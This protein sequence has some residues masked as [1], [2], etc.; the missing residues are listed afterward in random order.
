MPGMTTGL[1]IGFN[2][3]EFIEMKKSL[4]E[5]I[6]SLETNANIELQFEND[7]AASA[8][9]DVVKE[10]KKIKRTYCLVSKKDLEQCLK[11][12]EAEI[13]MQREAGE[14]TRKVTKALDRLWESLK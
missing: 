8:F 4:D 2:A 12:A 13:G 7:I 11:A 6:R 5:I 9:R 14:D 10:I 3:R 1:L